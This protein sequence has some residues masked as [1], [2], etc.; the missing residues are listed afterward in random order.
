MVNRDLLQHLMVFCGASDKRNFTP[1]YRRTIRY[2]P[3][4]KM[5]PTLVI[6][7]CSSWP[8]VDHPLLVKYSLYL[9]SIRTEGPSSLFSTSL[10]TSHQR[11]YP[12]SEITHVCLSH[13]SRLMKLFVSS[14][15]RSQFSS[16]VTGTYSCRG[17][18]EKTWN[19]MV[20]LFRL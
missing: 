15:H 2:H 16:K 19:P 5:F 20:T 1:H 3:N 6:I 10:S 8:I 17:V 11:F 18:L 12:D 4:P 9:M 14:V 7:C 13:R